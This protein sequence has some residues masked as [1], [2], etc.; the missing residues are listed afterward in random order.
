MKLMYTGKVTVLLRM[1]AGFQNWQAIVE[2]KCNVFDVIIGS[3]SQLYRM[4]DRYG[5]VQITFERSKHWSYTKVGHWS[6]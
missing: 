6:F 5:G 2:L 4:D 1:G 3:I